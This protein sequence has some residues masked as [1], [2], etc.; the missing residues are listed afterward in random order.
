NAFYFVQDLISDHSNKLQ[1]LADR[2]ENFEKEYKT[3]IHSIKEQVYDLKLG[4]I[5]NGNKKDARSVTT[6]TLFN[7][8]NL[9]IPVLIIACDRV[10]VSR[11][12]DSVLRHKPQNKKFPVIV[13][14]DCGNEQTSKVIDSYQDKLTHIMQPDTSVIAVPAAEKRMAGYYKISRHYRWALSQVFDVYGYKLAIIIED[15]LEV[16]SD[17]FTYMEATSPLLLS[18]PTLLCV[19]AWNDNGKKDLIDSSRNDLLYRSDFFPGLG[20]MLTADLWHELKPKW[21][22]SYWDDW[23]RLNEQRKGRSCIR[24]EIS[25]TQ[26][27]GR[28]GVS[29]GQYYDKHLKFIQAND[30]SYPFKTSNLTYLLK[31][32][33]DRYFVD[34]IKNLPSISP[35]DILAS[36]AK[37]VTIQY[38][39]EKEFVKLAK[40]LGLMSDTKDGVPRTSYKGIVTFY[41]NDC[42]MHL[43]PTA[44]R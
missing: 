23:L 27:F 35:N 2:L 26:T 33:Y 28:V 15:D 34:R 11:A 12:I 16:S 31:E 13:S 3:E 6:P 38:S 30:K 4:K 22:S 21:P 39:D 36:H 7:A 43:I 42:R 44:L 8:S 14:Q 25:R 20:W 9:Q 41:K 32:N 37:E 1:V 40:K 5:P 18:D 19:S 10:T 17:F 24:P 29:K